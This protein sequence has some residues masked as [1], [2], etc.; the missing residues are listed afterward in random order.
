MTIKIHELSRDEYDLWDGLVENSPQGTIFHS[1]HWLTTTSRSLKLQFKLIG[2]FIGDQLVGGCCF[3]ELKHFRL[4]KHAMTNV[5]L[6]PYSGFVISRS[7][8]TSIR[9]N[10]VWHNEIL[11]ALS[12]YICTLNYIHINIVNNPFLID[13]RPL[14]WNGWRTSVHYTYL[15]PLDT[16]MEALA[17]R[18]IRRSVKKAQTE[19]IEVQKLYDQELMWNLQVKT[20][21][22]QNQEVPYAKKHLFDLMD[23][24]HQNGMGE[25]W[26]ATTPDNTAVSAE[27]ILWDK[28]G[29]YRWVAAADPDKLWTGSTPFLLYE[30]FRDL[31][32][33]GITKIFMMAANTPHLSTFASNFNPILMPY[34]GV[35][36]KSN[37]F[38]MM[39][40][41]N[42]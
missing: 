32:S 1:I 42:K 24:V 30:I 22:K 23:M 5:Q 26:V 37:S 25:M 14:I 28:Q 35:T 18:N 17:S 19:R 16:D 10:E 15:L 31:Q 33:F 38:M 29:A 27:Y 41:N 36:N 7:D 2:A 8:R 20:Y 9:A 12:N 39:M 13:I 6:T 3:Y 11:S 21:E 4:L 34:Y 40:R